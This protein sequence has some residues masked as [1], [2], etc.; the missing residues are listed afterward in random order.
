MSEYDAV[1]AR[2]AEKVVERLATI[3][4]EEKKK[5]IDSAIVKLGGTVEKVPK[6]ETGKR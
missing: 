6:E 5:R 2:T 3:S 4:P 1:I